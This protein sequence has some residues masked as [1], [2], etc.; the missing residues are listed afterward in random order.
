MEDGTYVKPPDAR[1]AYGT[2]TL[3]RANICVQSARSLA[4]VCVIAIRYS[5]VRRQTEVSPG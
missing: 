2:M 1:L 4:Q 5:A 3:V